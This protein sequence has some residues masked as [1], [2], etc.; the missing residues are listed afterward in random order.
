MGA[1]ALALARRGRLQLRERLGG[2]RC[3]FCF[4]SHLGFNGP[5]C[6]LPA[7]GPLLPLPLPIATRL[8]PTILLAVRTGPVGSTALP[9]PPPGGLL[10]TGDAAITFLRVGRSKRLFTA[11]QETPPQTKPAPGPLS[12]LGRSRILGG[13]HGSGQLPGC[14]LGA[15]VT[16]PLRGVVLGTPGLLPSLP[17]GV[18]GSQKRTGFRKKK[19]YPIA[20]RYREKDSRNR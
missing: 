16:T 3:G 4:P 14:S 8:L 2:G 20:A 5:Q 7:C 10:P 1:W 19:D 17:T 12:Q 9:A 15:E 6:L 18:K 13:A 11:L